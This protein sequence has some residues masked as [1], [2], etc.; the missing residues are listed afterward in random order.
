MGRIWLATRPDAVLWVES[1]G[2][3]LQVGYA[4]DWLADADD[5]VWESASPERR[6]LASLAWDP[7][8]GDR[9]QDLVV[10]THDADPDAIEADLQAALLTDAELAAGEVAW[11]ELPD[12][13]GFWHSDPCAPDTPADLTAGRSHHEEEH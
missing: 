9:A 1:A 3:G 4:G 6:A 8:F 2:G 13:F 11:R 7:R 10:L 5:A 12:P